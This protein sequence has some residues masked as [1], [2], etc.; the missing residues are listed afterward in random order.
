MILPHHTVAVMKAIDPQINRVILIGVRVARVVY[1]DFG[2][3]GVFVILHLVL[4]LCQHVTLTPAS[5]K[6]LVSIE[7]R[8]VVS[9]P[10]GILVCDLRP[11]TS[12]PASGKISQVMTILV[13][14]PHPG[15]D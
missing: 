2:C 5:E 13:H 12:P 15:N 14:F 4:L 11:V 3:G 1:G 10:D 7:V 6:P 8:Y 9:V